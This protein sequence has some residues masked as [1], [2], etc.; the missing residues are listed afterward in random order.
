MTDS[1]Q[2]SPNQGLPQTGDAWLVSRCLAGEPRAFDA[3]VIKYQ[4]RVQRLISRWVRDPHTVEDL[5]QETFIKA[6]RALP[7]FRGEAQFYTWLYRIAVNTAKK[8]LIVQGRKPQMV[9][10]QSP[11]D[12]DETFSAEWDSIETSTD[13]NTPESVLASQEIARA[14]EQALQAL[15]ED[16]RE[17][18]TLREVE[19][20][21]YEDIAN[22]MA[23]PIG[24]VRS[25]IYRARE[26]ISKAIQPMLTHSS[27][28]RW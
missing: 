4:T 2:P 23:S 13:H 26:A 11:D 10:V 25:R 9:N 3:L 12:G 14:V 1:R 15:P 28:K 7:E 22:V 24:T 27:G 5:A 20:M 6:Y 8:H 21:S 16:Q 18:V 17:A 19:G